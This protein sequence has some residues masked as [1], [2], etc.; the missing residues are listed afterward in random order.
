MSI[1]LFL[2]GFS[3]PLAVAILGCI[4]ILRSRHTVRGVFWIIASFAS[5]LLGLLSIAGRSFIPDFFSIV[6]ANELMLS[7]YVLMHQAIAT[8]LDSPQRCIR[9]SVALLGVL[10]VTYS[11]YTYVSNSMSARIIAISAAIILQVSITIA[12]L[13]RRNDARLRYP[14]RVLRWLFVAFAIFHLSRIV[15]TALWPPPPDLMRTDLLQAVL[16]FVNAILA[17]FNMLAVLWLA[18][19]AQRD[20]LHALALTDSLTGLLNRRAFDE[21]LEHQ[22]RRAYR[23]SRQ[24]TLLMIDIDSFKAVNDDYGHQV[25]DEVIRQVSRVLEANTRAIDTVARYGGEE[26]AMLLCGSHLEHAGKVAERLRTEVAAICELPHDIRVTISIG[27]AAYGPQDTTASLIKR[28]D[29][30]LYF[31]K[32]SGRNRVTVELV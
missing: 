27:I 4:V 23:R 11:Y 24:F 21:I 12:V 22:L 13:Y 9:R 29:E 15:L 31:S 20:E 10:F 19:W 3:L 6:I 26:F 25:G 7:A 28:S 1:R 14:V 8:I 30:A 18:F 2:A 16:M 5:A 17:F 32:R